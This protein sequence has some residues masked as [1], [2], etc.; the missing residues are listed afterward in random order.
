VQPRLSAAALKLYPAATAV[1][2]PVPHFPAAAAGTGPTARLAGAGA[3][4][5]VDVGVAEAA[6]RPHV[7]PLPMHPER[8]ASVGGSSD[9][10][11][12]DVI[13]D[14]LADQMMSPGKLHQ[15]GTGWQAQQGVAHATSTM[16]SSVGAPGT[17]S[18]DI[19]A[20][21]AGAGGA[22]NGSNGMRTADGVRSSAGGGL[23]GWLVDKSMLVSQPAVAAAWFPAEGRP[24]AT[25]ASSTSA[26]RM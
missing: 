11:T 14:D 5:D 18:S 10:D 21:A 4:A 3:A 8:D 16:P 1:A 19:T 20:S 22:K 15:Q 12:V 9:R 13:M 24:F 2:S 26:M 23:L 6:A 7:A 17:A 25:P